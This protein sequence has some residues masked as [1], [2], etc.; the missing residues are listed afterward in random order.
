MKPQAA[1]LTTEDTENTEEFYRYRFQDNRSKTFPERFSC[2]ASTIA[3]S[4]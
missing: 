4:A 1:D 2:A 3:S